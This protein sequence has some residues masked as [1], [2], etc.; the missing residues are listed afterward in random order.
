MARAPK[1]LHDCLQSALDGCCV[2][3]PGLDA[4]ICGHVLNSLG[5]HILP[6]G[7][8]IQSLQ[9]VMF[10]LSLTITTLLQSSLLQQGGLLH[11]LRRDDTNETLYFLD[12]LL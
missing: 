7:T 5:I 11:N 3:G 10:Q 9:H 2:E 6:Q 4:W 1:S 8:S 12:A